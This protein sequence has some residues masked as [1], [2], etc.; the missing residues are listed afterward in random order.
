LLVYAIHLPAKAGSFLA[1]FSCKIDLYTNKRLILAMPKM[2]V[3]A[4]WFFSK[5]GDVDVC[6]LTHMHPPFFDQKTS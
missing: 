1:D 6:T 2:N 3:A 4:I 5:N